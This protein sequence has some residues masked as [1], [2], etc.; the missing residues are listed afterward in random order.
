M[1]KI[2][3]A[4]LILS[5]SFTL[6]PIARAVDPFQENVRPTNA[7]P[8]EAEAKSFHL[9]PGFEIQLVAS[10]PEIG[11]PFNIAFDARG[12]LWMTC[13]K[14]Y[15]FPAKDGKSPMDRIMI[16][17]DFDEH[18][19]A[20]KITTFADNLNIPVGI[21]PYKDGCIAYSIPNISYYADTDGDGKADKVETLVG[22]FGFDRD[23]HGMSS[24]YRRGFD[25]WLY[26][27]HGFNNTTHAKAKDGSQLNMESGN[28]YRFRV[29][30]SHAEQYTWGQTNPFGL[31]FDLFGNLYSSDSHSKPFYQLIRGGYY[32]GIGKTDDGLGLGPMMMQHLHNSTAIAS[33]FIYLDDKWPAEFRGNCFCGN[34]VTSRINRD[35]VT[36][37]GTS[38]VAHEQPDFLTTDDPW[39]RP[40]N[41]YLGPDGAMWVADFYNKIIGHYEVPLTHPA[42]DHDH[43][44]IWRIVYKGDKGEAPPPW[45][46]DLT[47]ASVGELLETLKSPNFTQRMLATDQ[48]SDR[49]GKEAIKPI[50]EMLSKGP[51]TSKQR[52]HGLWMLYRLGACDLDWLRLANVA[53]G[54]RDQAVSVHA[55]RILSEMA[56]WTEAHAS[57][58]LEGLRDSDPLVA[59]AAADAIGRNGRPQDIAA[60][61][62]GLKRVPA[63]DS[64]FQYTV[65]VAIRESLK[66]PNAF[67]EMNVSGTDA[68]IVA[69]IAVAVPSAECGKW[70]AGYVSEPSNNAVGDAR[71]VRHAIR[72]AP[73]AEMERVADLARS[74]FANDMD[75][76]LVVFK[77][78][79][80]ASAQRGVALSRETSDWAADLA[81]K[82]LTVSGKERKQT[83][84]RQQAGAEIALALKD[85]NLAPALKK[86]AENPAGD[87]AARAAAA[88]ALIALDPQG[89]SPSLLAIAADATAPIALRESCVDAVGS[90][91]EPAMRDALLTSLQQ[92]PSRLQSRMALAFAS[93][94]QG[95]EK[96]F[97]AVRQGKASPRLLQ[98]AA[99]RERLKAAKIPDAEKRVAELTRGYPALDAQIQSLI[100]ARRSA[101]PKAKTD[102]AAG[103]KVFE[104][105]CAACHSIDGKGGMAGPQLDG[106]G[107]RGLDRLLEDVLDPN[108][109]VDPAFHASNIRLK[110]GSDLTGIVR[111]EEG[112]TLVIADAT[113]KEA[114]I[115]R[116]Q[117]VE[118]KESNLSLMPT[119]FG[120]VIPTQDFHNLMAYLLSKNAGKK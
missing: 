6:V 64:H 112:Q 117:I 24:N 102:L 68:C 53:K 28:T 101:Y 67:A 31:A 59:R 20:R 119:N 106:V 92:A 70:L 57:F 118:R 33:T 30:G 2:L 103:Q 85:A 15:P 39:F 41:L 104:Q 74:Q 98:E 108:R 113:G 111:R 66:R 75:T 99:V 52:V 50:Q 84:Q 58:A 81:G 23:T 29:D 107:N 18:G 19:H 116:A 43:G 55:M 37:N 80:E 10:E 14:A 100:D 34:V 83:A 56:P 51:A 40:V 42:R 109:A 44:R 65:R 79:Q 21:Y 89:S 46:E 72:F 35:A 36:Y 16:L 114:A 25:G 47:K 4:A 93:D 76:Q 60:L 105:T 11:K 61:V 110:D 91:K 32:E 3:R 22:P 86:V 27:C 87:A 77:G 95:A 63:D 115:P 82:L 26:G 120:E 1:K 49:V 94:A 54:D 69:G 5:A 90:A 12:R 9:P 45:R 71:L 7:I 38:P 17:D 96:L 8:A 97:D 73:A 13:S 78:I 88:K 48:L 62:D